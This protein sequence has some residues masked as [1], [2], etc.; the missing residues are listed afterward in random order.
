MED[1]TLWTVSAGRPA[2]AAAAGVWAVTNTAA[3]LTS[4][5]QH[6][7]S[8]VPVTIPM[9]WAGSRAKSGRANFNFPSSRTDKS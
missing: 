8:S 1:A 7:R 6:S 3:V 2:T 4:A 5:Y 9:V